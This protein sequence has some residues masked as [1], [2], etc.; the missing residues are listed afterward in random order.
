MRHPHLVAGRVTGARHSL[1]LVVAGLTVALVAGLWCSESLGASFEHACAAPSANH[2]TCYALVD[3][4]EGEVKSYTSG[5]GE[6]GGFSPADLRSAYKLPA[7]GGS[8]QTVAVVDAYNDPDAESDLAAYR[9]HYGL[10]GCGKSGGCFKKVNQKGEEGSYPTSSAGWSQEISLDLDMVSAACPECHILLVEASNAEVKEMAAAVNEAT[11]LGATEISN[12]YG[13]PEEFDSEGKGYSHYDSYYSHPGIPITAAAGDYGYDNWEDGA[14]SPSFPAASPAVIAVGGTTLLPS[15]G[16]REWAETTWTGSGAGCSLTQGK[17]PWQTDAGCKD[18]TGNDVAAVADPGTP[19]S[20]Y[21]SYEVKEKWHDMGGTS[22]SAPLVA[23]TEALNSS[24]ARSI[25]AEALYLGASSTF[26]IKIGTDFPLEEGCTPTYFCTAGVGYDGPSGNGTPDGLL[27]LPSWSIESTPNPAGASFSKLSGVSCASAAACSA[28]GSFTSET[29]S[30]GGFGEIWNGTEWSTQKVP[31]P[32]KALESQLFGVSCSAVGACTGVGTYTSSTGQALTLGEH[33]NGTEWSV[34]STANESG[35]TEGDRLNGVS[36]TSPT[37]CNAVGYYITTTGS[38]TAL[39]EVWNGTEWKTKSLLLPTGTTSS[40]LS[41]VW[42][43]PTNVCTAVGSYETSAGVALTFAE[44]WNGTERSIQSTPNP[45]GG[46]EN[47][48]SGISCSSATACVAVGGYTNGS[49]AEVSLA[50][51]LAG[52]EWSIKPVP[53]PSA[54]KRS[55]LRGVSCTAANAC[56]A[57]GSYRN[58]ANVEMTLG[59]RWNGAEWLLMESPNP[60]GASASGLGAVSCSAAAACSATESY[61]G[62]GGTTA[63]LAERY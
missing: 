54:A 24:Y 31:Q 3:K 7:S 38:L 32:A 45:S 33:W 51:S 16:G 47:T 29:S 19:V 17:P 9:S 30:I 63:T 13:L 40:Y 11:T 4:T 8:G 1:A 28:V 14:K 10:S 12:S 43:A 57:V 22:V 56:E 23:G 60:G 15:E 39:A 50:E 25:G 21:D 18:R 5:S 53:S 37:D 46:T 55:E 6:L 36:C 35:E 62:S 2:V 48:L 58:S 27:E 42:C 26:D 52:T 49:G 41:A 44:H 34:Q 59:E 61:K 20:M